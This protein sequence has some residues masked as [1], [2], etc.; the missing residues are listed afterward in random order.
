VEQDYEAPRPALAAQWEAA[1]LAAIAAETNWTALA[2]DTM[3]SE[4]GV[5]LS[6]D[7]N[8]VISAEGDPKAG[9]DTYRITIKADLKDLAGLR[10]EALSGNKLPG[11]GPGRAAD[12]NF[13]LTE[14]SV[15]DAH[16]NRIEL[17]EA[18]ATFEA[19][20]FPA[21]AALDGNKEAANG[22][23]IKGVTGV[24]QAIYFMV[25]E[26]RTS[27]PNSPLTPTLSPGRG[28]SFGSGF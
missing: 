3:V 24:E 11:H 13:V 9:K 17:A 20:G 7:T 27:E 25:K 6:V 16:T 19:A 8:H 1:A 22:W 23:A 15:E 2:P 18:T 4:A 5:K 21:T 26:K 14:F 28:R 12:G 10:L